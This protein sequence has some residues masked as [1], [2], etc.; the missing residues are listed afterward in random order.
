M[1]EIIKNYRE[2]EQLRRSFQK[3]AIDTFDIDFEDWYQNGYWTDKYNPYSIVMDGK[4]VANVSVNRTIFEINGQKKRYIQLGT[5]MTEKTYRN[6]GLIR[7]IMQEID[8]DYA[9]KVDGM[10]LFA[11]D[12]VRSFYPKFG[13]QIAEQ[14]EYIRTVKGDARQLFVQIPMNSKKDWDMLEL[15]IKNCYVQSAFEMIDNSEL[16]MFYVTKYMQ[17]NVF[18]SESLDTYVI[19]EINKDTL[20]IH[21]V[22]SRKEQDLNQIAEGFGKEIHSVVLGFT[23]KNTQGFEMRV[24]NQEDC[25]LYIK[26]ELKEWKEQKR[27]IP[28]LAHA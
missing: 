12:D 19:A 23:P 20:T 16:N 18:Y 15:E 14:Y 10:Y 22:I 7:E 28:L 1:H 9:G 5:V 21:K 3:L 27:M 11:G 8:H 26:G 6:R 2:N 13:F 24:L 25:T 17:N 4:V